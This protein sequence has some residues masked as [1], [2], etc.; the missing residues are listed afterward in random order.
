MYKE[1]QVNNEKKKKKR[2]LILLLLLIFGFSAGGLYYY[3]S[4]KADSIQVV[5]GDYLPDTKGAQKMSDKEV[6]EAEQKAVNA[7]KFNMV[8]K[9]EA[10]FETSDSKGSLY[11]QNPVENGY[12][13]NVVIH[14]DNNNEQVYSSGAIQPGYEINGGKLDK[15]LPKGNHAAT[16]TFDIYD[17]K[18]N[19]KR[20]QVQAGITIR[21]NN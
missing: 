10:V 18:T 9:S 20:G 17:S 14:L 5:S 6:K 2:L 15:K 1:N 13:I 21:I 11:I 3:F 7:S 16:A 4:N 12:P 19:K 8:I